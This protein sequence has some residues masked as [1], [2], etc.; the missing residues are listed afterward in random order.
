MSD[1]AA[2]LSSRNRRPYKSLRLKSYIA[3]AALIAYAI[4]LSAF[5]L[6]EKHVLFEQFNEV[7]SAYNTEASLREV[8]LSIR[9]ALEAQVA[10]LSRFYPRRGLAH[11]RD[12]IRLL[13]DIF[14]QMLAGRISVRPEL[15]GLRAAMASAYTAPTQRNLG[16]LQRKLSRLSAETEAR[17]ARSSKRRHALVEGFWARSD[18]VATTALLLGLLGLALFGTI[19]VLFFRRLTGDMQALRRRTDEILEGRRGIPIPV[20]RNDEV[21]QLIQSINHMASELGKHEEALEIE[22]R[23]QFHQEKMAA[24]GTLA[25]GIAHEVGNPI[26]AI[27][28]LVGEIKRTKL[29]GG[30][31]Y[32]D[33][34]DMCNL[35]MVLQHAERLRGITQEISGFSR[36]ESDGYQLLDLNAMIRS[37][38]QLMRYDSRW[39]DVEL[40]LDLDNDLPALSAIGDQL[41]QVTMNLLVNGVDALEGLEGCAPTIGVST[42]LTQQGICMAVQDNGCGMDKKTLAHAIDTFYT[43]KTTEK[44]TGLGLS[45]CQSIV[46]A[47]HGWLEIES[48]LGVGTIVKVF[49][50][51]DGRHDNQG[52][53]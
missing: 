3:Y 15:A 18:T 24:I 16:A 51:L 25:A 52:T 32:I 14:E 4:F 31:P 30:C 6:Y 33:E 46:K 9:Y 35:E 21:G 1:N 12:H 20:E 29:T 41:T 11:A 13:Q 10:A 28:A 53:G 49:L 5:I 26:A 43:T 27:C 17:L 42:T 2:G 8:D 36:A 22:R 50:P 48:T 45:L 37:T 40:R 7:Q 34:T 23:K 39:K 44:G 47:H 38:C 19:N